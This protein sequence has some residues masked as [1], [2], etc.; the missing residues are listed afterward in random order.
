MSC[1]LVVTC[2][3]VLSI[4]QSLFQFVVYSNIWLFYVLGQIARYTATRVLEAG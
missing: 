1:D 3:D 2:L 4:A